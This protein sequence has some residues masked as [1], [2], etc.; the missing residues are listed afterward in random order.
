MIH[1]EIVS[2]SYIVFLSN[3]LPIWDNTS[4]TG[5]FFGLFGRTSSDNTVYITCRCM[6]SDTAAFL[7]NETVPAARL[8]GL[9]MHR[10]SGMLLEGLAAQRFP[11][12][13]APQL[14]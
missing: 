5:F 1:L 3:V 2:Q 7:W 4:T 6:S 14:H 13:P 11:H 8:D 12:L 10:H 9:S